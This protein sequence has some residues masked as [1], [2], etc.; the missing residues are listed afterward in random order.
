G[1]APTPV[2]DGGG[3]RAVESR[4]GTAMFFT[5]PTSSGLWV[6]DTR[7]RVERKLID[8]VLAGDWTNWAVGANA[9]V[10]VDRDSAG[11]QRIRFASLTGGLARVVGGPVQI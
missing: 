6:R 7:S 11:A 4:D 9:V 10:Y 3:I 1:S 2:T 5:R 8:D